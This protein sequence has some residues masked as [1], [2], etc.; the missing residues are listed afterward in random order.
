MG[1]MGGTTSTTLGL[2]MTAQQRNEA[3]IAAMQQAE[4][5]VL[6]EN[7]Q[8]T[9]A[10]SDAPVRALA[11]TVC[12]YARATPSPRA[13]PRALQDLAELAARNV[14]RRQQQQHT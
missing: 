4:M 13:R 12:P 7:S 10:A 2:S 3:A 9:V 6:Q 11:A 14:A 8:S 5:Q 1:A